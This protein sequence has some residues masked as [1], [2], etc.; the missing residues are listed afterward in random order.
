MR[1]NSHCVVVR[2]S[3]SIV[4]LLSRSQGAM[5]CVAKGTWLL[6]SHWMAW[7]TPVLFV[8]VLAWKGQ[9]S[10]TA[11]LVPVANTEKRP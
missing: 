9:L 6:R 5:V 4:L 10:A 2:V 8:L 11:L 7:L 3:P 1:L